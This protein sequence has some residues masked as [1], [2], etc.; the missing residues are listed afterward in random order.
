MGLAGIERRGRE[1]DDHRAKNPNFAA[2]RRQ[3]AAVLIIGD[4]LVKEPAMAPRLLALD[5]HL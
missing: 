2:Q 5:G 1:T 4:T 3:A